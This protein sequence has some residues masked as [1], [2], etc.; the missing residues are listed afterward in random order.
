V[1]RVRQRF[2]DFA[3]HARQA[4]VQTSLQGVRA[5]SDTQVH[6][7]VDGG[8]AGSAIFILV[9]AS[10]IGPM[11]QADQPA[12]NICSGF[13]P[14]PDEPGIDRLT[15]RRPSELRDAPSRPPVVCVFPVYRTL[16]S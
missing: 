10:P 15:S 11:K 2:G 1:C 8:V 6:L 4:D 9:A 12:A 7:S 14:V 16:L 5:L 13:V 3:V